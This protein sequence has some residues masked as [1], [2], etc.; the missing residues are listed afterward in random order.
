MNDSIGHLDYPDLAGL[1]LYSFKAVLKPQVLC[2]QPVW[3]IRP[4]LL[5]LCQGKNAVCNAPT[6]LL[7]E[8]IVNDMCIFQCIVEQE[9]AKSPSASGSSDNAAMTSMLT[10]VMC[11]R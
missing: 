6:V 7:Q 2:N 5:A 10:R 3:G 11:A 4:D 9:T 8:I 1:P